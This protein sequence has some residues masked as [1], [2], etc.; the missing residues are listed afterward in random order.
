M[1]RNFLNGRLTI[2]RAAPLI[3][4]AKTPVHSLGNGR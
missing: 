1:E 3:V 4:I 2:D